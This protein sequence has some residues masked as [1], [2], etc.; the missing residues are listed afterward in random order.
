VGER[1][2]LLEGVK[3]DALL[4]GAGAGFL[5]DGDLVQI[6]PGAPAAAAQSRD[7]AK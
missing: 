5:N 1:I 3:D 4:V 7:S 2:E 6:A